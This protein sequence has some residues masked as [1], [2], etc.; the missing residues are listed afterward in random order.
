M[1]KWISKDPQPIHLD[2]YPTWTSSY[3]PVTVLYNHVFLPK[4]V[5]EQKL[6]QWKN[7]LLIIFKLEKKWIK[8]ITR[9][10][11]CHSWSHWWAVF[12]K[13]VKF[14]APLWYIST[15]LTCLVSIAPAHCRQQ[16][17]ALPHSHFLFSVN[18]LCNFCLSETLWVFRKTFSFKKGYCPS[19][20]LLFFSC[21]FTHP[22]SLSSLV[23]CLYFIFLYYICDF[24]SAYLC[25]FHCPFSALSDIL[26]S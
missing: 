19:I 23:N 18:H 1:L 26:N 24:F 5:L 3:R 21:L 9:W 25:T 17:F 6:K 14:H 7:K 16:C 8:L 13:A 2:L 11:L 4:T 12:F 22:F 20:F 15:R 10:S